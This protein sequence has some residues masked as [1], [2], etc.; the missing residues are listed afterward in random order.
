MTEAGAA[1]ARLATRL[2]ARVAHDLNNLAAVFSGHIYLLRNSAESPEE[3]FEAMEKAM[4]HLQRLTQ[5]LMALGGL[6]IGEA[7]L[8]DINEVIRSAA[9]GEIDAG[10]VDLDL[11]EKIPPVSAR[12]EDLTRAVQAL[13][14]NAREASS[15][16]DHVRILTRRGEGEIQT[17]IEDSGSGVP[18]EARRRNFDPFF[19]TKGEKGRGIGVALA[20]AFAALHEGSFALEDRPE[21]GT[22]ATIRLPVR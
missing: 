17:V 2:A 21:G 22:R 9:K 16:A 1:G 8:L 19:S 11:E 6:G 5:R 4:E 7:E 14:S 20:N 18:S 15:P 13:I 3:A 10:V 12:R